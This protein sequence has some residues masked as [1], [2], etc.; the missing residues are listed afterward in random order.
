MSLLFLGLC[1][2]FLSGSVQLFCTK[3]V[4]RRH[5]SST[6]RASLL[7]DEHFGNGVHTRNRSTSSR[8]TNCFLVIFT[9]P[10]SISSF[11]CVLSFRACSTYQACKWPLVTTTTFSSLFA[12]SALIPT[13]DKR[14]PCIPKRA[15]TS[16]F[17]SVQNAVV[18]YNT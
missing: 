17:A 3:C 12:G 14:S 15:S 5:G 4:M 13:A 9:N 2:C 11:L 18:P 6:T 16:T 1:G 8:R 10:L 7:M